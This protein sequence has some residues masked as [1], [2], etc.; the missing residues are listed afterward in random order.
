MHSARPDIQP[1]VGRH[2]DWRH[3]NRCTKATLVSPRRESTQGYI[4]PDAAWRGTRQGR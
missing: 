2:R 4:L 3:W 1:K